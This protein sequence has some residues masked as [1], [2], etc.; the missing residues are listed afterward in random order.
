MVTWI[1]LL[2]FGSL[3]VGLA[4]HGLRT[5][6]YEDG[7]PVIEA[8]ILKVAGEQ[9]L[10]KG[11]WG[12]AWDHLQLWLMLIFGILGVGLGALGLVME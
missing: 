6:N 2:G 9:P 10:P 3:F 4:I 1:A 7:I 8:A 11:R 12:T 5:R